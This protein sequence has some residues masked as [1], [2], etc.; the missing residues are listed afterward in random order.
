SECCRSRDRAKRRAQQA[1]E[2][3]S[4]SRTLTQITSRCQALCDI[5]HTSLGLRYEDNFARILP[6]F[7][8][9]MGIGNLI[10][11]KG[12]IYVRTNPTF[13]HAAHYFLGPAGH[14]FAFT[15]HVTQVQAEDALITVHEAQR[16]ESRHLR[17]RF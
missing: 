9:A 12:A 4:S 8:V 6:L 3:K 2:Q 10:E 11:W 1:W 15:P 17:D 5:K 16:V 7:Q 13:G 14:L